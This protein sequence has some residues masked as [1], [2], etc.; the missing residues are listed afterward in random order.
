M[1][2]RLYQKCEKENADVIVISYFLGN[3]FKKVIS[4]LGGNKFIVDESLPI[5]KETD[6]N[7]E[8]GKLNDILQY[9]ALTHIIPESPRYD[10]HVYTLIELHH[11][12]PRYIKFSKNLI[13]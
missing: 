4:H 9:T 7:P 8:L 13:D 6:P 1:K 2:T 11:P 10:G 3:A 5:P 12:N